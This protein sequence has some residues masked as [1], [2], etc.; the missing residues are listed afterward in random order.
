MILHLITDR[1][2]LAGREAPW[3]AQRS[4]LLAQA[5]FAVGAGIDVIQ[6]RERD[7]EA[8]A[9]YDLT[10]ELVSI[11]A[12]SR[13]RVIVND[14]L[15]VALA[16][17]AAGVHLR[18]DSLAPTVV[19]QVVPSGFLV[20]RSVHDADAAAR[21]R[22]DVDYLIAGTVWATPSKPDRHP[23]LGVDGLSRIVAVAGQVPVLAIGGVGVEQLAALAEAGA[24]GAAAI[25]LFIA[26]ASR[27]D[28]A[29]GCGAVPLHELTRQVS[30]CAGAA[31]RRTE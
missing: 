26:S 17:G 25:G 16:A 31:H 18:D 22:A 15:D 6:V 19:R 21:V 23:L 30:L 29:S 2:R 5:R 28:K 9:L 10:V 4:C 20:G 27:A 11:A 13:T 1:R 7:L 3:P 12:G 24:A 8:G 14:R